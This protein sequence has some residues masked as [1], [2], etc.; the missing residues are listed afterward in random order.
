MSMMSEVIPTD[1]PQAPLAYCIA[2]IL[3]SCLGLLAAGLNATWSAAPPAGDALRSSWLYVNIAWLMLWLLVWP[4]AALRARPATITWRG[5]LLVQWCAMLI[6]AIPALSLAALFSGI[7]AP[8]F[9]A[10]AFAQL[11]FSLLAAALIAIAQKNPLPAIQTFAAFFLA[12][13]AT[14][15]PVLY[16]LLF[17]FFPRLPTAWSIALPPLCLARAAQAPDFPALLT[18]GIYLAIAL[19]LF[20]PAFRR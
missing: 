6:G 9:L 19:L 14:A 16:F 15:G 3:M 18:S 4:A 13:S 12:A 5:D 8:T 17:N 11:S 2:A 10:T 1:R 7:P 20:I